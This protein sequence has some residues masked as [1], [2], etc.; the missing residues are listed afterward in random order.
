[1]QKIW[2]LYFGRLEREK[3]FDAILQMI[4]IFAK[5]KKELP[6][7][8]FVF[9]DGTY[10]EE[11]KI[12]TTKHKE[13]HY[14]GRQDRATIKRYVI[15]CQYYLMPSTFLETFGLTAL[16]AI[17]RWLPVIGFAK[18]GLAPFITPELDLTLEYGHTT[19]EKLHSLIQKII[20]PQYKIS[21]LDLKMSDYSLD[22]R[23][24]NFTSLAGS[25][26]K[27]IL[28]VSDFKNR[29]WGIESY[30]LDTADILKSMGYEI[31]IFGSTLPFGLRGKLM[32]YL[33]ILLAIC[34]DRQGTRLLFKLKKFQPDLIRYHSV[35]RHL[36][37]ESLWMS[38]FSP[39][40]KWMMYHDFGYVH[41]FPH[42]LTHVHQIKTP[43]TLKHFLQSAKTKNPVKRLAVLFKYCSVA[44]IKNQLK[45]RIDLHL[46]PSE[47]MID[48]M[49]KSY[50]ISKDH[51]PAELG[52][53]KAFPHFVQE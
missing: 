19:A 49:Q 47:F 40:K 7:E 6:F 30:I 10:A 1:M 32:K 39:A 50:K 28:L 46:V 45:K 18:G 3:W 16:T 5:E 44:L 26:V 25:D 36:G 33:W 24:S 12:L 11:L 4:E 14:F 34:N 51:G 2:L 52:K 35:L 38:K 29:I 8:L 15:N 17:A 20:N 41:P 22:T 53:I 23:K 13:I 21:K 42:E 27:K 43:F 48:I 31:E 37:W 9:G